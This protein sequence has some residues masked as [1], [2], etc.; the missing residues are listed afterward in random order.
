MTEQD[1]KLTEREKNK[2]FKKKF[3]GIVYKRRTKMQLKNASQDKE[4]KCEEIKSAI[5]IEN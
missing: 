3:D 5:S 2:K 4:D 1:V